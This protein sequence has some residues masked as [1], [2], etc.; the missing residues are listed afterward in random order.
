MSHSRINVTEVIN[1]NLNKTNDISLYLEI[2]KAFIEGQTALLYFEE[3]ESENLS[4]CLYFTLSKLLD[5]FTVLFLKDNLTIAVS[6]EENKMLLLSCMEQTILHSYNDD[7]MDLKCDKLEK[8][9]D[10]TI[11]I[12]KVFIHTLCYTI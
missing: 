3:T 11:D 8:I 9:N 4:K 2:K 12:L 10:K 5:D 1:N 7:I 6:W